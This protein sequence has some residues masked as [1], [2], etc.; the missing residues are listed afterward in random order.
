MNNTF[1]NGELTEEVFMDQLEGFVNVEK[2]AYVCK[3]HKSLY[4]LKQTPRA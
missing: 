4:G 2:P 1:F 3:L